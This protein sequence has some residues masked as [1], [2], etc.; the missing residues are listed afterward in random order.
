MLRNPKT[1]WRGYLYMTAMTMLLGGARSDFALSLL[2]SLI[3]SMWQG[4]DDEEDGD[5]YFYDTI[6]RGNLGDTAG[7][8]VEYGIP[9]LLRANMTGTLRSPAA[10]WWQDGLQ[11]ADGTIRLGDI[12]IFSIVDDMVDAIEYTSKG[13]HSKAWEAILP[14]SFAGIP[15]GS[16]LRAIRES[17]Y[18]VTDRAG[19]KRKDIHD[20]YIT[21]DGLDT[22][23]RLLGFNPVSISEKTDRVWHEKKIKQKYSAERNELMDRYRSLVADPDTSTKEITDLA[24]DIEAYNAKVRR[25]KRNIPLIEDT[26]LEN[27]LSDSNNKFFVDELDDKA[28]QNRAKKVAESNEKYEII[29]G[30]IRQPSKYRLDK[31]TNERDALYEEYR[32]ALASGGDLTP[33]VEKMNAFNMKLIESG[34]EDAP[35]VTN[36][37]LKKILEEFDSPEEKAKKKAEKDK[38]IQ[39]RKEAEKKKRFVIRNGRIVQ[40]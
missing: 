8:F 28:K 22:A 25:S 12:A 19:R 35:K 20:E 14:K 39:K 11:D 16:G 23:V 6:I 21:P 15:I 26:T 3:G 7:N 37:K 4:D 17:E 38:R 24:N 31:L 32:K 36:A 33:I 40:K 30:R 2:V 5:D 1:A 34:M 27:A 9:G 29:N 18:G 13:Q 10:G